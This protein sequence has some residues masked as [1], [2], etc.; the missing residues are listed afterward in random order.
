MPKKP[1]GPRCAALVGPY[2][3]GK[4]SLLEALLFHAGAINRKGGA[5]ERNTVGD[6][7]PEA[8][9]R[10]MGTEINVATAEY[11]GESWTFID[12]PG[13]IELFQETIN[14]LMVVDAA[15]LV[16]EPEIEK[17]LTVAPLLKFLGDNHIP[18]LIFINKLDTASIGIRDTLDALQGVSERPLV[19]REIPI[20]E[21]DKVTG[22]VDLVSE[23]A[24]RWNPNKP[25]D[26]IQMPESVLSRE[27][28]ARN[29][30]LEALAD[31]DDTLLEQLL[32]DVVPSTDVIYANLTKDLQDASIVPVFFGAAE[33]D[34]GVRRLMKALRHE[35]PDAA[36]TAR[37]LGLKLNGK[38]PAAQVFKTLHAGH[39][40]KLS[41]A[42]LWN[43]EVAD[44]STLA[45]QRVGGLFRVFGQKY[46][47]LPKAAAGEV[48]ALGRLEQVATGA[49]LT[50]D[51]AQ[52]SEGWPKPLT[53]LFSLAIHA[54]RREDEVKLTGALAKL[55]DEDP[56][57]SF[58]HSPDTGELLLWGQGEMHLLVAIDRLK[59]RFN[60]A[61]KSSR[62]Q[63]PYK[64]TIR[65][66]VSQHARHKKQSGGHGEFGDVHIDIKPLPRGSGFVF[67]ETIH[68]GTVPRQY[69][70]AVEAG[71]REYLSRGPLGFPVVDV[72]VTLTDGQYHSVDS[73]EMAFK[74]AAQLA[75]REGM[76]NCSPVL[77]E[78]IFQVEISVPNEF[79][80]KIQRLVSGR[81]GQILGFDAKP[82]WK[83][84]DTVTVQL[85]QA[86]MHDLIIELR[87]LTLGVGT[88]AWRF[89]HLQ[90][91]TGKLADHV[92]HSRAQV[93]GQNH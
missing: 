29:E 85:P 69:I 31:F 75:M 33:K 51:R 52:P 56:S 19:L 3:S 45:G 90:E 70:P 81:R 35:A 27:K 16:C 63:V 61:V 34:N 59:H 42:R 25:S 23:R 89:D 80:S 57:L 41:F 15:V 37:R 43:G 5:K 8:R 66:S 78:P 20:R 7:Q 55:A 65:K 40:G 93:L 36:V 73:S 21:G 64:E 74:K 50:A 53:P 84:W 87:S 10:Q 91:L 79:T 82:G 17:S 72:A 54:E 76:P 83:G 49:V 11:L 68:G 86:E 44:G 4:T 28:E 26:L 24:F 9:A 39:T 92:V 67:T 71:V 2:L 30:M 38:D 14:A 58:G 22:H 88:F 32:E 12:C 47:K 6:G 13:S 18:H 60:L 62:P 48:V 77:L 46:E 1:S